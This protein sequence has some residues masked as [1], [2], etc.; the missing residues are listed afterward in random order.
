MYM[1]AVVWHLYH[2]LVHGGDLNFKD[3]GG[4][5]VCENY[6]VYMITQKIFLLDYSLWVK[7]PHFPL[8][9]YASVKGKGKGVGL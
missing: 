5:I 7:I 4:A 1:Y 6:I 3:A 2:V 8:S 9:L